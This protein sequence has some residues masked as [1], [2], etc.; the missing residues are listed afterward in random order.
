MAFQ[1]GGLY[2]ATLSL[3]IARTL[4]LAYLPHVIS[5]TS[6]VFLIAAQE[7]NVTT[8]GFN[9]ILPATFSLVAASSYSS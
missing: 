6:Y 9:F 7:Y 4:G 2:F 5:Y 8:L 3:A 1:N